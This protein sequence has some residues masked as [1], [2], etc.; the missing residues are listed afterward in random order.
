MQLS[1]N[2]FDKDIKGTG[3]KA[4]KDAAKVF[5]FL[6]FWMYLRSL[7]FCSVYTIYIALDVQL[8]HSCCVMCY[9]DQQHATL[10]QFD[11]YEI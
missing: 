10:R 7:I 1:G 3:V 9:C 8:D 5:Y 11:I 4:L 2:D 6:C